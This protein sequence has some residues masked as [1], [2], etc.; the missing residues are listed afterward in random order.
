MQP[1]Q[2]VKF[3]EQAL[4][5]LDGVLACHPNAQQDGDQLGVGQGLGS[6]G[7]EP[8]ARAVGFVQVGDAVYGCDEGFCS[9]EYP[10]NWCGII[11]TVNRVLFTFQ[12]LNDLELYQLFKFAESLLDIPSRLK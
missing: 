12:G 8:L 4:A 6:Q 7:C 10:W 3:V 2:A 5:H 11:R 9:C 1:A